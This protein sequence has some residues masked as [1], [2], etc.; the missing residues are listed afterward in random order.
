MIIRNTPSVLR[1]ME[2]VVIHLSRELQLPE[3][4]EHVPINIKTIYSDAVTAVLKGSL[5]D[6]DLAIAY[7]YADVALIDYSNDRSRA[8]IDSELLAHVFTKMCVLEFLKWISGSKES[9]RRECL[10][11]PMGYSADFCKDMIDTFKTEYISILH[12]YGL[13]NNVKTCKPTNTK[14]KTTKSSKSTSKSTKKDALTVAQFGEFNMD[15]YKERVN[16]HVEEAT[17]SIY[18]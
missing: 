11:I 6:L 1:M 7:T 10:G 18:N 16:A 17:S 3:K 2:N 12:N 5:V 15:R 4:L 13:W 9:R 8:R 14:K